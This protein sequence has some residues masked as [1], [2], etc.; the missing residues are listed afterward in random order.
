M[1]LQKLNINDLQSLKG[2]YDGEMSYAQNKR[3]QVSSCCI[4]LNTPLQLLL[5]NIRL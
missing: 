1:Y 3:Q 2:T 5:C 4:C